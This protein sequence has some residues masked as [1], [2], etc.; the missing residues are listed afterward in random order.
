MCSST[1]RASFCRQ[2]YDGGVCATSNTF[3]QKKGGFMQQHSLVVVAA[4]LVWHFH[5]YVKVAVETGVEAQL[6]VQ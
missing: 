5:G 2:E 3:S 6:V 1:L 4:R